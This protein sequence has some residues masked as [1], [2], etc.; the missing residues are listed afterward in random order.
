MLV[1]QSSSTYSFS[2]SGLL[3]ISVLP[4]LQ[5][6]VATRQGCTGVI[7][8]QGVLYQALNM[9]QNIK[10]LLPDNIIRATSTALL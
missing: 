2:I 10:S 9:N 4:A 1:E 5:L 6:G 8:R 3:E 7:E